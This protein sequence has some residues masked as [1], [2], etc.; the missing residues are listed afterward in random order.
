M[1]TQF[2]QNMNNVLTVLEYKKH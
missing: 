1:S 2:F